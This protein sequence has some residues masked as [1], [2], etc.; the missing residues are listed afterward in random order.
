MIKNS[1]LS[2]T[3]ARRVYAVAFCAFMLLPLVIVLISSFTADNF[4]Q[5]PPKSFGLRW[6]IAAINS[7]TLMSA[8]TFSVQIAVV[9]VILSGL[10]GICGALVLARS[11]FPGRAFIVSLLMAPLALPHVVIAIGLLHLFGSLRISSSPLGLAA[12]HILVTLPYVL[13]LT[14][15]SLVG[16]DRHIDRASYSLG[17]SYWQ[18]LRLVTL[19]MIAPGLVAGLLF[20]FLLSFD[21]ATISLFTSLPGHSTLPAEIFNIASQGSDPVVTSVSG[22]MIVVATVLVLV[23]ERFFGVLRLIANEQ[24]D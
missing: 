10:L 13:R 3:L 2:W 22:L 20:A 23:I 11:E 16:L 14:M 18:T 6:Y 8:L 4:V 24:Q 19:P 7:E 15:T 12:G 17:A 21:E 1:W 5:F 9:V